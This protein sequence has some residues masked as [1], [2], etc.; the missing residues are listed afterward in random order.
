MDIIFLG[1]LEI[2]QL[3]AFMTGKG[4][5][6]NRVLDIEMA[7]DIQKPLRPMIYNTR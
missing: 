5:Q 7:F 6:A 1:G 4:N 3:S 2:E